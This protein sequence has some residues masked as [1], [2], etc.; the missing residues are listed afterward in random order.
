MKFNSLAQIYKHIPCP[1]VLGS[2][3]TVLGGLVSTGEYQNQFGLYRINLIF[4]YQLS[5]QMHVF[6]R[7][8][9]GKQQVLTKIF[10]VINTP[11]RQ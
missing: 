10:S 8:I 11:I 9:D 4:T 1:E 6:C 7:M 2:V 5:V 3:P